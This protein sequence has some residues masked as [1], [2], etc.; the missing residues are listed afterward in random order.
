[1]CADY[2][3]VEAIYGDNRPLNDAQLRVIDANRHALKKLF[4]QD[5]RLIDKLCASA[6][7]SRLHKEHI[8]CGEKVSDKVDRLLDIVR[9][10]SVAQ[11]KKLVELYKDDQP[12]LAQLLE[13]GGKINSFELSPVSSAHRLH[14]LTIDRFNIF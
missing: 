14:R 8:K 6:C 10:Q 1:V 3:E 4:H 13:S 2:Q 7:F 11:L 9:R 12:R 5:C